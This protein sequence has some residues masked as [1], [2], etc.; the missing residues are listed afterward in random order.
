MTDTLLG[1]DAQEDW[2]ARDF[3]AQMCARGAQPL[4]YNERSAQLLQAHG[5]ATIL[6][7]AERVV[8][9]PE[10]LASNMNRVMDSRRL[11]LA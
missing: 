2:Q 6:H 4:R 10:G 7:S 5:L 1:L 3:L 11:H 8:A 9:T